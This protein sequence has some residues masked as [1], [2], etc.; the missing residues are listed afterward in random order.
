[1]PLNSPFQGYQFSKEFPNI[2]AYCINHMF[3]LLHMMDNHVVQK[4]SLHCCT[5]YGVLV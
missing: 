5:L 3:D 4:I 2:V 1:M